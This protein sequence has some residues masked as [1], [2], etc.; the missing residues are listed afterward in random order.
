MKTI[1]PFV[2]VASFLLACASPQPI[3]RIPDEN[4]IRNSGEEDEYE[5][6][7]FDP[8]FETWFISRS[9]PMNFY[10]KSYYESKNRLYVNAWNDLFFKYGSNSP[11]EYQI[12]YDFTVDYGIEL[13]YKL[14]WYFK[15]IEDLYGRYYNFPA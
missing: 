7:I 13:N 5:L 8:G 3:T 2:L 11:F 10:S 4:L 6:I 9:K 14:F 15:Y 12:N 1:I